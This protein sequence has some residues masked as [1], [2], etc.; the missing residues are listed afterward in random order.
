MVTDDTNTEAVDPTWLK[1]SPIF[2]HPSV[3]TNLL[4]ITISEL[5]EWEVFNTWFSQHITLICNARLLDDNK[6][7]YFPIVFEK[8]GR[9]DRDNSHGRPRSWEWSWSGIH[10]PSGE[11]H[12]LPSLDYL[13]PSFRDPRFDVVAS[14]GGLLLVKLAR[15]PTFDSKWNPLI[16]TNPLTKQFRILPVADCLESLDDV[17]LD[18]FGVQA[19]LLVDEKT[20]CYKLILISREFVCSYVST[21]NTW[22]CAKFPQ[23]GHEWGY[24]LDR[25]WGYLTPRAVVNGRLFLAH[26]EVESYHMPV[27]WRDEVIRGSGVVILFEIDDEAG[28]WKIHN[29]YNLRN[30]FPQPDD[31]GFRDCSYALEIVQCKGSVY[32]V[33][34]AAFVEAGAGS[35]NRHGQHR[36]HCQFLP[37]Q[38]HVLQLQK[39]GVAV[40]CG[41]VRVEL[42]CTAEESIDRSRSLHE[43][44][45]LDW[46]PGAGRADRNWFWCT[47]RGTVIWVSWEDYLVQF[48]VES[49]ESKTEILPDQRFAGVRDYIAADLSYR[50]SFDTRP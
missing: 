39:D 49:G 40:V 5:R 36:K 30:L 34:P 1:I 32:A 8:P 38:F 42:P 3:Y 31:Q 25:P 41:R 26:L 15:N 7:W 20:N 48:D 21:S 14:S 43:K 16:V 10:H 35:C 9:R 17:G 24:R 37:L 12:R 29:R 18:Y 22:R 33:I 44:T 27:F 4:A 13:N 47:A 45:R 23:P 11:I 50:P 19:N 46:G 2:S 28:S 6:D